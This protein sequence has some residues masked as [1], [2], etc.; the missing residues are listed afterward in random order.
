MSASIMPSSTLLTHANLIDGTGSP[1]RPNVDILIED[2]VFKSITDANSDAGATPQADQVIDLN[3]SF[4]LPGLWDAHAHLGMVFPQNDFSKTP[5]IELPSD[6]TVR[7]GRAAM[8]ALQ[9]GITNVRVVGEADY[10][11]VAWKKAFASGMFTGPRLFVC[12]RALIATGGHGWHSGGSVEVDGPAEVRKAAREQMKRGADQV[13]LMI[14]GGVAS[15]TETMYESQMTMDEIEAAVEVA[16][17]K[18]RKVCAHIGGPLGAKMAV[19]AGVASLEHGYFLDDEAIELMVEHGTYYV[20]TLAVTQDEAYIRSHWTDYAIKKALD[21]AP[22]H[23]E[24]FQKALR[25]GVKIA[26][27]EDLSP[28]AERLIPEIETMVDAGMMPMD[29]IVAATHNA[30]ELCDALDQLGTVE[31]GKLADLIVLGANP[32]DNIAHLHDLHIVFKEGKLVVDKRTL[33]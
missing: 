8:D 24:S 4:V 16:R 12:G 29:A 31:T 10:V 15:A 25:A 28:F 20:P 21:A 32:L 2:G 30:A 5:R 14:T 27:G 18:G 22:R 3:G 9:Y 17:Y 7:C 6:R 13:K 11:D 23:R 26:A 33:A 19:K 1:L